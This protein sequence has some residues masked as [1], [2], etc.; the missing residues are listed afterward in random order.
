VA[1]IAV[2]GLP[3][4]TNATT[5]KDAPLLILYNAADKAGELPLWWP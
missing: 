2:Q 5:N 3:L 1:S 4:A